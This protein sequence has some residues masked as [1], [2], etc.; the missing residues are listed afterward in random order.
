M[1]NRP[2]NNDEQQMCATASAINYYDEINDGE[3]RKHET[4]NVHENSE[5]TTRKFHLLQ[6][7]IAD[8]IA[9]NEVNRASEVQEAQKSHGEPLVEAEQANS[10]ECCRSHARITRG[11]H[12]DTYVRLDT[13]MR[14]TSV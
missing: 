4:L 7:I 8:S 5:L 12:S 11:N 10:R 6:D 2:V 9:A 14:Q 13:A 1:K 3:I